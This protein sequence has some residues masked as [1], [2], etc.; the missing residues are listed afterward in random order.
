MIKD[1][2]Y[3]RIMRSEHVC[4][5]PEYKE[6]SQQWLQLVEEFEQ[7]LTPEQIRQHNQLLDIQSKSHIIALSETYEIGFCDGVNIML[8]VFSNACSTD[9]R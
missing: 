6:L 7:S 1:L 2:Y 8:D 4:K 5:N 9:R 3:G